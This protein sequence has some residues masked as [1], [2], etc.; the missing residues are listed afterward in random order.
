MQTTLNLK[1]GC[2]RLYYPLTHIVTGNDLESREWPVRQTNHDA[3]KRE[4]GDNAA[5]ATSPNQY[6]GLY[7]VRNRLS[8]SWTFCYTTSAEPNPITRQGS[9]IERNLPTWPDRAQ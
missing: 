6:F 1:Y 8:S 7:R 5:F 3:P 4:S 9:D 2:L